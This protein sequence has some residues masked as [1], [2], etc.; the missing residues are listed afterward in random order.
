MWNGNRLFNHLVLI[1][2]DIVCDTAL[3]GAQLGI[4]A[5]NVA[6]EYLF[7]LATFHMLDPLKL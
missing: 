2:D 6:T 4:E 3:V 5:D 7:V 1:P